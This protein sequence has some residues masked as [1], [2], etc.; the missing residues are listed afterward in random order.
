V[1][2]NVLPGGWP[3]ANS[4]V[5]LVAAIFAVLAAFSFA[6][7]ATLAHEK[8]T[9]YIFTGVLFITVISSIASTIMDILALT[10]TSMECT[11]RECVTFVPE[12][13][14]LSKA[15]C[16]CAPDGWFWVTLGVDAVLL[17]SA[18]TCLVLTVKPLLKKR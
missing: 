8:T 3:K 13:I 10:K 14:K 16:Q 4:A 9:R 6:F 11:A 7:I 15:K 17:I 12:Y 18:S 5:R 2:K 1:F